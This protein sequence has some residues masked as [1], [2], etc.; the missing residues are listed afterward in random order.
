MFSSG[1]FLLLKINSYRLKRSGQGSVYVLQAANTHTH[2]HTQTHMSFYL[3]QNKSNSCEEA[4]KRINAN[5]WK[6]EKLTS[7]RT[8]WAIRMNYWCMSIFMQVTIE[9]V[10]IF[11]LN[12]QRKVAASPFSDFILIRNRQCGSFSMCRINSTGRFPGSTLWEDTFNAIPHY[13][14]FPLSDSL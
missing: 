1:I 2:T 9:K 6:D 12:L 5:L 13:L 7:N 3:L 14:T 10:L 11:S 8:H 4:E